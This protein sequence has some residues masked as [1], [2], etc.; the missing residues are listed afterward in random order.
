MV[1]PSNIPEAEIIR[2]AQVIFDRPFFGVNGFRGFAGVRKPA[3][4]CCKELKTSHDFTT[5]LLCLN[6][7]FKR[8][9]EIGHEESA[10]YP[11]LATILI[12]FTTFLSSE[13]NEEYIFH[14]QH[15][16]AKNSK[17]GANPSTDA[18]L[19]ALQTMASSGLSCRT[20]VIYELKHAVNQTLP[21][22]EP[23]Y[24]IEVF[25]QAYYVMQYEKLKELLAC[26]TDLTTWHYFKLTFA[27]HTLEIEAHAK[28]R[29][30]LPLPA[31]LTTTQQQDAPEE[32]QLEAVKAH[33]LLA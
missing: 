8:S 24:L 4:F 27:N 31:E 29:M 7:F 3:V 6:L 19:V 17:R 25:L 33:L 5:F 15:T 14:N 20:K 1:A 26:L 18:A 12:Y 28:V 10:G 2:V 16:V 30:V 32:T 9:L 11:I 23:K 21:L 22:V 13:L